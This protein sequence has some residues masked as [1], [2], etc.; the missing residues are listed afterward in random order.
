MP[1]ADRQFPALYQLLGQHKKLALAVSGGPDS[2]ALMWL[3]AQWVKEQGAKEQAGSVCLHVLSIDHGLRDG[4]LADAEQVCR[5]AKALDLP[6]EVLRWH[7]DGP[8][9]G[10]QEKARA[11]RYQLMAD[12]CRDNG[13]EAVVTAHQREDQAETML[14]RLA[15]GS[16]VDGLSAMAERS[17]IFGLTVYRPLLDISRDTLRVVLENAGHDWLEDPANRN[18]KFERVRLRN[19]MSAMTEIE[20]VGIDH[21]ALALSAKRLGRARSALETMTDRFMSKA[22]TVF[23]TGHC[24]IDRSML[25]GQPDEI[26]LRALGRLIIWASGTQIT[27]SMAKL[28]RLLAALDNDGTD[29]HTLA[30]AQIAARKNTIIIGREFG[31][32][33]GELQKQVQTWDNRFTFSHPRDVRPYGLFIDND[34]RHRPSELPHFVTCSLPVFCLP[35]GKITV[36]HL[37]QGIIVVGLISMPQGFMSQGL[38]EFK[39]LLSANQRS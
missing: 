7:H 37:D 20:Q 17:E 2:T 23:N 3:A 13:F 4:A 26:A 11:G 36:P 1:A 16:G 22:V 19:A 25:E 38:T 39:G 35:E 5:W 21:Q 9:S 31:R 28:E 33:E 27:V 30:G 18:E 10:I 24:E 8:V 14:M 15:R 32:V 34:T 12:W 6:C 29:R